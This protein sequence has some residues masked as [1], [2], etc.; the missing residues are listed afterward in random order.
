[1]D[2]TIKTTFGEIIDKITILRIKLKKIENSV[3]KEKFANEYNK[4]T[5]SH[6]KIND[7]V[8]NEL[9]EELAKINNKI[10]ILRDHIKIKSNNKEFDVSYIEYSE[11]YHASMEERNMIKNKLTNLYPIKQENIKELKKIYLLDIDDPA[12]FNNTLPNF[13]DKGEF[14]QSF[15][16]VEIF[17]DRYINQIPSPFVGDIYFWYNSMCI[18]KGI[19]NRFAFKLEDIV[20]NIKQYYYND[21]HKIKDVFIQYALHLLST[22][23]YMKAEKYVKYTSVV[24]AVLNHKVIN[25]ENMSYFKDNDTDKTI[26][27]YMSGGIGDKIMYSRFMKKIIET[28]ID[29][30]N[31]IIFL[32]DDSLIWIFNHIY[33]QYNNLLII[34]CSEK[35]N[36]PPFDYHI[37]TCMLNYC[38]GI[39]NYEDIYIDYYLKDISN[40]L[41]NL[42]NI[43]D[44]NKYNIVINWKGNP[45][46]PCDKY[47]RSMQLD[48]LIPFFKVNNINWISVQKNITEDEE[49]ILTQY[50]VKNI[51]KVLDNDGESFKD[52]LTLLRNVNL[53]I[54]TDT[55]LI[56]IA[57]TADINTWALLA[58][59]CEWRWTKGKTTNWYPKIKLIRQNKS[60]DWS[61]VIEESVSE[62]N[63]L[64]ENSFS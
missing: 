62:L 5:I 63:K 23:Q 50:N 57:G 20:K 27:I 46:F 11:S 64:T 24:E 33:T 21:R 34:K 48:N 14:D 19:P 36:L 28:N 7:I 13:F 9:F 45:T 60:L 18:N 56:H 16:T 25:P 40:S 12:V 35:E 49:K 4:L 26:L 3:E 54:T 2:Y 44:K 38:I 17:C 37:N 15:K 43:V 6:I 22:N 31:K 30:N 47:N 39:Y 59:G 29:K 52:T 61:N 55:S 1:M 53:V 41:I 10:W 58:F 8:F 51:G 42:D 32:V